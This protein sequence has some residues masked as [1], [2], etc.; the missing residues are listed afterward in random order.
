[1]LDDGKR[2]SAKTVADMYCVSEAIRGL[3]RKG[4]ISEW[5]QKASREPFWSQ[6]GA[7]VGCPVALLERLAALQ[8]SLGTLLGDPWGALLSLWCR[9][10]SRRVNLRVSW[11]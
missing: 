5:L 6:L 11:S 10:L 7:I 9:L 2:V 4:E 3:V 1:M 8:V